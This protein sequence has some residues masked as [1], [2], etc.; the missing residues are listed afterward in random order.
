VRPP[1]R[2]SAIVASIPHASFVLIRIPAVFSPWMQ[3][4]NVNMTLKNMKAYLASL[5]LDSLHDIAYDASTLQNIASFYLGRYE[6]Y[7]F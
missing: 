7:F 5:L 6:Q 3:S 2:T 4:L 1:E